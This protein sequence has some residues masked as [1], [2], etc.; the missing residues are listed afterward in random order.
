MKGSDVRGR[1]QSYIPAVIAGINRY[2]TAKSNGSLNP[3]STSVTLQRAVQDTAPDG[4]VG[5]LESQPWERERLNPNNSPDYGEI[6]ARNKS[7]ARRNSEA[8]L[9]FF[10]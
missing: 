1:L 6:T 2:S 5:D 9:C 10:L 7:R 3:A 4:D 8:E